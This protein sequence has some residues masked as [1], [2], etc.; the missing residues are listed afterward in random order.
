MGMSDVD[1]KSQD[2]L[3]KGMNDKMIKLLAEDDDT[4]LIS[5]SSKC[6]NCFG[7]S[8]RDKLAILNCFKIACLN[9]KPSSVLLPSG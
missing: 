7:S 2:A 8:G 1:F 5:I 9:Y 3:P 4:K 6:L